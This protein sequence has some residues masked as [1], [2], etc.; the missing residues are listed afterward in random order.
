MGL[1]RKRIQPGRPEL[2]WDD[3]GVLPIDVEAP[4]TPGQA[5]DVLALCQQHGLTVYDAVYLELA[6]RKGLPLATQD[7][8][9]L[10]AAQLEGVLLIAQQP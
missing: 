10:K 5:K 2:F 1:R 6:K 8:D 4:L 7:S 9:L 3:L